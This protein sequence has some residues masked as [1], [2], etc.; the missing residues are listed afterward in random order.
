MI[1]DKYYIIIHIHP[2]GIDRYV[3]NY[4]LLGSFSPHRRR[5]TEGYLQSMLHT[6]GMLDGRGDNRFLHSDRSLR[7]DAVSPLFNNVNLGLCL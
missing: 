5:G 1:N 4:H 2:E 7:D 6:F 3:E